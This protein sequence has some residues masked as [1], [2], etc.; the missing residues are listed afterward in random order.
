MRLVEENLLSAHEEKRNNGRN[1]MKETSE[2]VYVHMYLVYL[3]RMII[4]MIILFGAGTNEIRGLLTEN[5]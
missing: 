2:S 1:Y 5:G 4:Y 3:R